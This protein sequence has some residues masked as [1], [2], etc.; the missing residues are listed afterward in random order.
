MAFERA[1]KSE[2]RKNA[3]RSK[4]RHAALEDKM[5]GLKE[6]I[7]RLEDSTKRLET[8]TSRLETAMGQIL[9]KLDRIGSSSN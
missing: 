7:N 5:E 1:I 4:E 6:R 3:V 8:S 9:Q 2:A